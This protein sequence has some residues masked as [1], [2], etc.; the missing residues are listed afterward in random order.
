MRP[1]AA[2]VLLAA[3]HDPPAT[4]T[5]SDT[6]SAETETS[7]ST[8]GCPIG[9]LNCAC[10]GGGVCDPGLEC[11]ANVCVEA[12]SS[13]SGSSTGSTSEP[14]STSSS[15]G[16]TG[17]DLACDPNQGQPNIDCTD[18][19]MPFCAE[20]GVCGGCTVLPPEGCGEIDAT[21]PICNPDDG[22]CVQCT[23]SDA[24]LCTDA[25][26]ACN[27][28][29]NMCDGCFLHSHCPQSA[30]DIGAGKCFPD[31][32]ILHVRWGIPGQDPCVDKVPTGGTEGAPYC[33]M[34]DAIAHAQL[35]GSS[36]WTFKVMKSDF[37]EVPQNAFQ[38][39]GTANPVS[40][41]I[42]HEP[43]TLDDH[44]T[45]FLS[46]SIV[47]T[48]GSNVTAY[49][50]NFALLVQPVSDVSGGLYCLEGARVY[51]DDSQIRGSGGP[52]ILSHGCEIFLRNSVITEGQTEGVDIADSKLHLINSYI[53]DNSFKQDRGGGGITASNTALD[54]VYSTILN[55]NNEAMI[56]GDS[57][58]CR[59]DKVIGEIRN[60]VI[61]RIGLGGNLSISQPCAASGLKVT[62]SVV[63]SE[64]FEQGNLK[65]AGETIVDLFLLDK[66]TFAYK[67]VEPAVM[68]MQ[69]TAVWLSGDVRVDFEGN[70]RPSKMGLPDYAGADV[71][72]P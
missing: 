3:C 47:M 33:F 61:A 60:S 21:R 36:G 37:T 41:A 53:T 24:T 30:C 1:L 14:P 52:G 16:S 46:K 9:S 7:S 11:M 19:E 28:D 63:D 55:N 20:A 62:T 50:N 70:P 42:I 27:L 29:T 12:S 69:D 71:Y 59:D 49:L 17:P 38:I 10:T 56:G 6:S 66:A 48:V 68:T 39:P 65:L 57:L 22:K 13:T 23:G 43:G 45:R 5:E 67:V 32:K 72:T 8:G 58:H 54:I 4:T 40:Y 31:D 26:P 35:D 18:P 51:L 44:H 25:K 15:S 64:L 2:L 34:K